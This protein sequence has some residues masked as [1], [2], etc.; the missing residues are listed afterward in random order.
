M[1]QDPRA[2]SVVGR[3]IGPYR[4]I[5]EIGHGGMGTV[6]LAV[7]ADDQFQKRAAIKLVRRGMDTDDILQRFRNE[8]QILANLDHPNIARL[9]DGGTTVEGLP[10]FVMDYV[11]GTPVDR[12][13]D[14]HKLSV[15]QRLK[16][17][18]AVCSAIHYAHQN[19]I[20]HR[21]I[22]PGNILV[23]ANGVPILLDFGIAKL[24]NSSRPSQTAFGMRPL[25]P[26]CASPE[27]ARGE[28]ITT[29]SDVYS[30]GI[31]L[32]QL[33]TGHL[34]YRF[35]TRHPTEIVQVI[36][37]Q[38][39]EKPSMAIS[40][41]EQVPMPGQSAPVMLTPELVSVTR[42]GEPE[43]LRRL[44]EGDLDTIVLKAM[45]KDPRRRYSSAD[46]L[47]EDI[48]RYLEGLPVTARRDT[49]GYRVIKFVQRNKVAAVA[50]AVV[51]VS[52]IG[53]FVATAWEAHIAERE[54]GKAERRFN[55]VRQLANSFMFEI[56]DAIAN[57]PGATPARS[58]LVKRALEYLDSLVKDAGDN[59][60]LQRDLAN[61]YAKVGDVQGN[62]F[63][64]NLGDTVGALSS[65][66]KALAI[67]ERLTAAD[68]KG[69]QIR[70]DLASSYDTVGD[71]LWTTGELV[72]ALDNYRKS[73]AIHEVV[74]KTQPDAESRHDLAMSFERIGDTLA[75]KGDLNAALENHRNALA[76][77]ETLSA[78]EPN[79]LKMRREVAV[80]YGKVGDVL[81]MMGNS[82]VALENYR[83]ALS[84]REAL[85]AQDPNNARAK[86]ELS[87][88]Y[89]DVAD[90]L[91]GTGDSA[92]VLENYRKALAIREA[93][94]A[95]D[96]TNMQARRDLAIIYGTTGDALSWTGD[97]SGA[98]DQL[99]KSLSIFR[100]L[101]EQDP[102][103][104]G[105]REDL[106]IC[107]GRLGA[108]MSSIN[109]AASA[110]QNYQNSISIL[111]AL[112]AADPMNAARHRRLAQSY[113]DFGAMYAKLASAPSVAGSRRIEL[114]TEARAWYQKGLDIFRDI[115]RRGI[116]TGVEPLKS[117][118]LTGEI[119]KCDAELS[120]LQGGSGTTH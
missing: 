91:W 79:N 92:G 39:P 103:N 78:G 28:P 100:S 101:S 96:P 18:R 60:G 59:P 90:I 31:L 105:A 2:Q 11:E 58:L 15:V 73:L 33:L 21:D 13:C 108:V 112:A 95:A 16:L 50:A 70:R 88:S 3:R 67:R 14:E 113:A 111:E 5:R 35:K 115:Q 26:E 54:R 49:L 114:W 75:K 20:V 37:N 9:L 6:Y 86:R 23:T 82:T 42:E 48:R 8:R 110:T 85:A 93:L 25:T 99:L 64:A 12:Y 22:K 17:F 63:F 66:R 38:E 41:I 104:L 71:M 45:H 76:I 116:L 19:L 27:Q 81:T 87:L 30:L 94:S 47:S 69:I 107:Y 77:R 106:A 1:T 62:P 51:A 117:N 34:P 55:E 46:Q 84:I 53:G 24:L 43:K 40:R 74:A 98:L 4:V 52:L 10:Y 83:K 120:K 97:R 68:P 61:A 36:C 65:Y 32:Y 7:R 72:G 102:T 80:S 56:H 89:I 44:L 57:L 29:A 118:E 119:A 109:D